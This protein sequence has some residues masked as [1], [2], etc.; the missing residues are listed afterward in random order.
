MRSG[1]HQHEPLRPSPVG[2]YEYTLEQGLEL[3]PLREDG[4]RCLEA[5]EMEAKGWELDHRGHWV[6]P[7]R[8]EASREAFAKAA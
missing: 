4:R 8:L 5:D 7:V 3:D 6:D 2:T 1:L